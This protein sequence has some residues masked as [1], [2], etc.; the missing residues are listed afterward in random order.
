MPEQGKTVVWDW[1]SVTF[2]GR[3]HFGRKYDAAETLE[4]LVG[5]LAEAV[6]TA[7]GR[8]A[9]A[10]QAPRRRRWALRLLRRLSRRRYERF[11]ELQQEIW[12]EAIAFVA[13][14]LRESLL[15]ILFEEAWTVYD[16]AALQAGMIFVQAEQSTTEERK[17]FIEPLKEALGFYEERPTLE[18]ALQRLSFSG[19]RH[20]S[21]SIPLD[22]LRETQREV[23]SLLE[24]WAFVYRWERLP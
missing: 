20:P 10:L 15:T 5:C 24:P 16:H 4:A 14:K 19:G 8:I 1:A 23:V 21:E 6:C 13:W 18:E 7:A 12:A 11:I 9:Q 22:L 2:Q 3:D 17:R